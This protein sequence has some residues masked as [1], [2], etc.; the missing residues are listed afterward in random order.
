MLYLKVDLY[1]YYTILLASIRARAV[2][3]YLWNRYHDGT[4]PTRVG[5]DCVYR[6]RNPGKVPPQSLGLVSQT[7]TLTPN[8]KP[9]PNPNRP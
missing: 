4:P 7:R 3:F 6:R 2:L 5:G 1:Y 8:P 9:K